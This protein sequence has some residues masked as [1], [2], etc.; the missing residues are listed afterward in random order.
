MF[1]KYFNRPYDL[2]EFPHFVPREEREY[3][4]EYARML[5]EE[6]WISKIWNDRK[7]HLEETKKNYRDIAKRIALHGGMI[8]DICTGPAGGFMPS[9]LLLEDYNAHIMINDLC[10]SVLR[11]WRNVFKSIESPPPNIEFAAFDVCDMPFV[12]NSIDVISGYNAIINIEGGDHFKALGQIY[13]VLRPGGL[14]VME[15]VVV[16]KECYDT[17]TPH[18]QSI[19]MERYP[20]IFKDFQN[21]LQELGYESIETIK[22][23]TWS[24]KNDDSTLAELT[25]S[26]GTELIFTEFVKYCIK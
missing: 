7:N 23:G 21:E 19:F 6:E 13:R 11:E 18:Q 25:R 3:N 22:L 8:L 12:D 9:V 15:D 26:L 10:P 2:F 20:N 16:T 14:F 5:H 1:E 17:L 4:K 24:N